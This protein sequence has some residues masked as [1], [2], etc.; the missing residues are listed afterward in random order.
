MKKRVIRMLALLLSL[1]L[2]TACGSP[3]AASVSASGSGV[4]AEASSAPAPEAEPEAARDRTGTYSLSAGGEAI[5]DD[6]GCAGAVESEDNSRVF[7]EIFV[8][9]FSDSDG[10]G[11]GDLRGVLNRLDYLNDGDPASGVSLGVEGI[12]LSPIFASGSYH[13]YDV[14]DY[15][16]IDPEF[17]TMDDLAELVEQC[18]QR[19]IK[20]ILDLPINHTGALNAWFSAFKTAH[21][22]GDASDPYYDFYCWYGPEDTAPAGRTFKPI[23]ATEDYYECNFSPDMPEL[24]FDN[25]DV[26]QAVLD[27]A[28][29]YL[30]LGVDGFR[31]DAAKYIYFGDNDRSADFW[32][33]YIWELKTIRTE[34]YTVAEV[35]DSDAITDLY[36]PALNCFDF[37]TAQTDGLIASTAKRGDVNVYTG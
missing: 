8:G 4:G 23:G 6:P 31:F 21:R 19:G 25:P 12:W 35:W 29:Y 2:L 3:G 30:E 7:Y 37:T 26:R 33:W 20:V 16:A 22:S 28:R 24:N 1:L 36:Y 14:N 9:S 17:G 5:L 10:D 11:V 34:I 15:Y 18:H 13:K 32:T 27:V